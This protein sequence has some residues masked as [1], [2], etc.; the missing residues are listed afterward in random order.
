V[1]TRKVC[2]P[3]RCS[4]SGDELIVDIRLGEIYAGCQ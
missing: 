4:D 3:S 1:S 2:E